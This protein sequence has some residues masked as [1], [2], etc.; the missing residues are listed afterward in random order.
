MAEIY[1]SRRPFFG[2]VIAC[3]TLI[4][5]CGE[6]DATAGT[7]TI[8]AETRYWWESVPPININGRE[9]YGSPCT[10][11]QLIPN[12]AGPKE[13]RIIFKVPSRAFTYCSKAELGKNYLEYDGEYIILRVQRQTVGAGSHTAERYRSADFKSWEEYIG[14]SWL[15]SE[16]Y[17]AWRKVG[18]TSSKADSL[19]KIEREYSISTDM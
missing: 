14:V 6:P 13:E 10:V 17:E 15:D 1:K 9:L 4:M 18:S 16:K 2:L 8:Q 5:A 7:D 11:T 19:K 3:S 12:G